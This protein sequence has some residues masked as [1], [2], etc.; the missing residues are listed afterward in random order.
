MIIFEKPEFIPISNFF[1][2][3]SNQVACIFQSRFPFLKLFVSHMFCDD[4]S[5]LSSL[6]ADVAG[7]HIIKE[8]ES[9]TFVPI[10]AFHDLRKLHRAPRGRCIVAGENDDKELGLLNGFK[11]LINLFSFLEFLV[12]PEGVNT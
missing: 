3:P 5:N 4:S 8:R 9:H 11:E 10:L 7:I 2:I 12:I 6:I 1:D